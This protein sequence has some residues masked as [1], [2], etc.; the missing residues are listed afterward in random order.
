LKI[1]AFH[2]T[3]KKLNS[4]KQ[5]P[6]GIDDVR[7]IQITGRDLVKHRREQEK[8]VVIDERNLEVWILSDRPFHLECGVQTAKA[9]AKNDNPFFHNS[10]TSQ[11][12][13]MAPLAF[14]SLSKSSV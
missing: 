2:V 9:T 8:V 13:L 5:L 11:N 10:A 3:L 12:I 4:F 14:R 7:H 1:N 6:D